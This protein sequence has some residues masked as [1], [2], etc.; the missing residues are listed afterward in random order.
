[1]GWSYHPQISGV[2]FLQLPVLG[3]PRANLCAKCCQV[4][5]N[6]G[7]GKPYQYLSMVIVQISVPNEKP[8]SLRTVMGAFVEAIPVILRP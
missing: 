2:R 3:S 5:V 8:P 6:R 4:A 7:H 1:M